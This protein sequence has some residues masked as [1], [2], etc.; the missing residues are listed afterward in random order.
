M[1]RVRSMASPLHSPLSLSRSPS[2]PAFFE[3]VAYSL[4]TI[5][6]HLDDEAEM[7]ID[8][9][10]QKV[11]TADG[12]A[13]QQTRATKAIAELKAFLSSPSFCFSF[14]RIIDDQCGACVCIREW[15]WLNIVEWNRASPLFAFNESFAF[16]RY[17]PLRIAPTRIAFLLSP[18]SSY[19]ALGEFHSKNH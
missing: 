8:Y 14:P 9:H 13:E 4:C 12:D 19:F 6:L 2:E 18:S 1:I 16:A 17:R 10:T 11:T 3:L 7:E 5:W 15:D